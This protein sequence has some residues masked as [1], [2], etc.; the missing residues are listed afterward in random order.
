M[1]CFFKDYFAAACSHAA[2]LETK[3]NLLPLKVGRMQRRP[4][5]LLAFDTAVHLG[6]LD[7]VFLSFL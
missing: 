6:D 3:L 1:V 7:F 4:Q 2:A 5:V